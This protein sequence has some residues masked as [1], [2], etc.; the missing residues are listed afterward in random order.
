[1]WCFK[2][3]YLWGT[4]DSD[5]LVPPAHM[6]KLYDSAVKCAHRELFSVLGGTHN[7]TFEVAGIEYYRRLGA[8]IGKYVGSDDWIAGSASGAAVE[9]TSA[10]SSAGAGG[11]GTPGAADG[12]G[13]NRRVSNS[14]SGEEED[15]LMV[16]REGSV[17]VPTMTRTFQ[18]K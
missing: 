6:R 2:F 18:V 9:A 1:M 8:F 14:G 15:Y 7:D 16:D 3:F 17:H 11:S 13:L 4:G 5:E 12:S 10:G